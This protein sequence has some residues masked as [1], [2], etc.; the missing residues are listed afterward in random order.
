[1]KGGVQTLLYCRCGKGKVRTHGLCK[2][3]Y[4]LKLHDAK[5]FGGLREVVL[6]RDGYCCRVCGASGH[7]KRA[8]VV[9]HRVKGLSLLHLMISL[10][11][12]CHAK[13]GKTKAALSRMPPLLLM[14]WREQHP[15]GHEQTLLDFNVRNATVATMP[16]FADDRAG[17]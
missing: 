3:C 13:V 2:I 12:A 16:L 1:M 14:L 7:G 9:H 5:Y 17:N 4:T 6:K 11:P 10:C 8:I 15:D